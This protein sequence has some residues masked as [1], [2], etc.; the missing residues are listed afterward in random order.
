MRILYMK[1][2]NFRRIAGLT[3]LLATAAFATSGCYYEEA[4]YGP[5]VVRAGYYANYGA[6][7][8][9]GYPPYYGYGYGP[10]YGGPAVS[11]GISSN[12]GRYYRSRS[13]HRRGYYRSANFRRRGEFRRARQ[14]AQNRPGRSGVNRRRFSDD[15]D[16]G[17]PSRQRE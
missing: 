12:R 7:Y 17:R 8:Y 11:V 9:D 1:T 10:Y 14:G 2:A 6:P 4:Y 13:R 5:R 16:E 3:L 15:R